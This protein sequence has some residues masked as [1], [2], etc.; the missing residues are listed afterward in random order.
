M[1]M[2]VRTLLLGLVFL[3][4]CGAVRELDGEVTLDGVPIEQGSILFVPTAKNRGKVASGSIEKGKFRLTGE[5]APTPG[6]YLVEIRASRKTGKKVRK[7][8]GKPGE[9]EDEL[10]EAVA[11]RYNRATKLTTE[12]KGGKESVKFAVHSR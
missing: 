10:V 5:Q 12:I 4:G 6:A 3:S 2:P 7:P 11:P 1:N 8:Y 9:M